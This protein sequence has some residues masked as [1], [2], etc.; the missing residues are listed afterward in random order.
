MLF[1]SWVKQNPCKRHERLNFGILVLLFA[2]LFL[3]IKRERKMAKTHPYISGAVSISTMIE[4]LRSHFPSSAVTSKTV[5]QYGLAKN[6]ESAVIN[7]LQFIEVIDDK[8]RPIEQ[9]KKVFLLTKDNEFQETFSKLIKS[10][11]SKLFDLHG[12]AAWTLDETELLS[13]FRLT[14]NTSELIGK[15]Q[16]SLFQMF[17]ALSGKTNTPLKKPRKTS[18][19]N[20]KFDSKKSTNSASSKKAA[21]SKKEPANSFLEHLGMS[22][23]IE[24]NLPSDA[25]QETYDNI[26]KSIRE[27][28]IDG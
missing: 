5:Q 12:D 10:S 22:I 15:R 21:P 27:N 17:S 7:A 25:S 23:K 28:L 19:N 3:H 20:R 8:G 6:N 13:F 11:Y 24:V 16:V 26:F 18:A 4:K 1:L 9:N 2:A 14:D